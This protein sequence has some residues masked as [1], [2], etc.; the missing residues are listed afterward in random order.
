MYLSEVVERAPVDDLY[1]APRHPYSA[2]LLAAA[3]V[4]DPDFADRRERIVLVGD[5]P[6][7]IHPPAGCRF[8][9]RCPRCQPECMVLAPTLEPRRGDPPSHESACYY[10]L[11]DGETL[12]GGE[13]QAGAG[14]VGTEKP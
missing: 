7:P 10:A 1:R 4:P 8:S 3:P 5:L 6:S 9:S 14:P 11:A 2:A 12:A 13:A